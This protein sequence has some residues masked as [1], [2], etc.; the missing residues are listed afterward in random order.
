M[1][2]GVGK[3]LD[4]PLIRAFLS[5]YSMSRALS[6]FVRETHSRNSYTKSSQIP[7]IGKDMNFRI[8]KVN[9]IVNYPIIIVLLLLKFKLRMSF[10]LWHVLIF[11]SNQHRR[12]SLIAGFSESE[13]VKLCHIQIVRYECER[14][15]NVMS[16]YLTT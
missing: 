13:C 15:F 1:T 8:S 9:L 16:P 7:S 12:K 3:T 14:A 4:L 10:V 6:E 2:H 5:I 11:N